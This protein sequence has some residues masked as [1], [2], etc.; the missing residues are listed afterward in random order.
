MT[1]R[2][3]LSRRD[4]LL[5][6][7]AGVASFSASGW[8]G[9][10]AQEATRDP[11]RRRSCILLWMAGGP[12]QLDTFDLKPGHA[13]GG[14]FREIATSVPGIRISEH[15][16]KMAR[17]MRDLALVRSMTSREGDHGLASE[18]VHTGYPSRGQV[19]YPTLGSVVSQQLSRDDDQ[20]PG[21]VSISPERLSSAL[22]HSPG[23]L[24]PR[25]SPLIVGSSRPPAGFETDPDA[26]DRSLRLEDLEPAGAS[27]REHIDARLR[28]LGEMQR[29]FVAERPGV[30]PESHAT[31]YRRAAM[32]MRSPAARAFRLD[33]EPAARRDAYGRNLFGQGCLMARRLAEQGVPFIEVAM[34]GV[35][36]ADWDTHSNNF[37]KVRE[38]SQ[39]L[40]TAWDT[41]LQ[42]LRTRG[43]LDSTLVVW[44]GEFGRTPTINGANG[45][46][47]F[48]NAWSAVLSGG[49]IRGGQVV[50][51]TSRGGDEVEERPVQVPDL[52]ATICRALGIDT[53]RQ[54][55]SNTGRPIRL[56]D[57][58]ARPIQ[59]VIG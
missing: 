47:H 21:F 18:R 45:R 24:G 57:Q 17:R 50:G 44:M 54:N 56:V 12:S 32:L 46:D 1:V 9:A 4:L 40:D 26:V 48:P 15:L 36:G 13:N 30:A 43:L 51:R 41:L 39:V 53:S 27:G 55:E 11:K 52:L 28:L 16:P 5:F 34:G 10:L 29:E 58:S 25:Y 14:P 6:S 33:Q 38:M 7:A 37:E 2:T 42:D 35:S 20:L 49:G 3:T 23:F 8:L 22:A 59:E 19:Q 31:A